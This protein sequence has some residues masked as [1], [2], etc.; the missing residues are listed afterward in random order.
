MMEANAAFKWPAGIVVLT[1]KSSKD[2]LGAVV[3]NNTKLALDKLLRFFE[4]IDNV[5]ET[6]RVLVVL[7]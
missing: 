6:T 1:S 4:A 5:S 2:L 7:F 3:H